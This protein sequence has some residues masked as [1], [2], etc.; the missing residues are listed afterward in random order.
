MNRQI[1]RVVLWADV[2]HAT[3]HNLLPQLGISQYIAHCDMQRLK[4]VVKQHMYSSVTRQDSVPAIFQQVLA[5]LQ[6]LAMAKLLLKEQ[7]VS[8]PQDLRPIFSSLLFVTEHSILKLGNTAASSDVVMGNG[9]GVEAF[10]AAAL[11]FTFHGL[12]DIAS[13]AAFF[14]VLIQRLRD[15]LRDVFDYVFKTQNL[16]YIPNKAVAAPFLLWLCVN[17]WKVSAIESR[18]AD[19]DFFVAKAAVVCESARIDSLEEFGSHIS[20]V[21]V[22]P[23]YCIPACSGLW[24]DI[25]TWTAPRDVEGPFSY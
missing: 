19:R 1:E 3:A 16:A 25:N 23:E 24:A 4:D 6:T 10:K 13:T 9:T 21:V 14:D 18:R 22:I 7:A 20:R 2:L 12:R 8:N 15:G 17:G 11:I 5:D